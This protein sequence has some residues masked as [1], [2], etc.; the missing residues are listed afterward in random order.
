[1]IV[2]K[3]AKRHHINDASQGTLSSYSIAMMVLH[4]LQG[5]LKRIPQL[6]WLV[7]KKLTKLCI[8]FLSQNIVSRLFLLLE[9]CQPPVV[10]SLQM[11]YPVSIWIF[12]INFFT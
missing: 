3:W 6:C 9:P 1:M 10:P 4:Y 11:A 5:K 12:S 7:N 2:K 8:Y